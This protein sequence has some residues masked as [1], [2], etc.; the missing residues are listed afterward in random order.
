MRSNDEVERREVAPT[1][2]EAD[3]SQ[4]STPSV[5]QQGRDPRSLQ[6]I[7]RAHSYKVLRW[8]NQRMP[9]QDTLRVDRH[10]CYL[11]KAGFR[12]GVG[13]KWP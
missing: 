12:R 13:Q 5:A 9:R 4:S 10:I 2:I 6:P 11:C 3:L 1:L 7:V 8:R